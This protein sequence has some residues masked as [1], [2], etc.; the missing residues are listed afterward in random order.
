MKASAGSKKRPVAFPGEFDSLQHAFKTPVGAA[1]RRP[2][3]VEAFQHFRGIGL[4]QGGRGNPLR[5]NNQIQLGC[6]VLQ[7]VVSGVMR[8]VFGVKVAQNADANRLV[9][10]VI[11][12]DIIRQFG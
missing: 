5:L 9:H 6:G 2:Q 12:V 8:G 4:E 1:R 7:R 10:P 11:L 3:T